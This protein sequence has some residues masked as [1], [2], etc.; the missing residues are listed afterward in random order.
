M[1]GNARQVAMVFQDPTN[2]LFPVHT[3]STQLCE[4]IRLHRGVA[5]PEA[6]R[7]AEELLAV[8]GCPTPHSACVPIAISSPV[9][10]PSALRSR[11][12][13]AGSVAC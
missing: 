12:P 9:G 7:L 5:Q 3:V 11:W 4:A 6:E 2:S 8:S 1:S 10:W 13:C